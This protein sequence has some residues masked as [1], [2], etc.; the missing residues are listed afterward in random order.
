MLGPK[1]IALLA[2]SGAAGTL[3]RVFVVGVLASRLASGSD[4]RFPWPTFAVN[5]MG[6]LVAGLLAGLVTGVWLERTPDDRVRF[7]VA[8]GFLGAFTTFSA[9]G[10]E[11]F[12]LLR[13]GAKWQAGAYAAASVV[14]GLAMV[15]IGWLLSQTLASR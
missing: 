8:A 12:E 13:A 3:C 4:P 7:V 10:L 1:V 5:L 9:F 15:A 6:C 2:L 14:G 11:T